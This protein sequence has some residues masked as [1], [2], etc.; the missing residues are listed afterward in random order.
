MDFSKIFEAILKLKSPTDYLLAAFL[1]C[2]LIMFTPSYILLAYPS[3]ELI[4]ACEYTKY[5]PY[6]FVIVSSILFVKIVRWFFTKVSMFISEQY[7]EYKSEKAKIDYLLN[8]DIERMKIIVWFYV[9][10]NNIGRLPP[11]ERITNE[12]VRNDIIKWVPS[13]GYN[14]DGNENYILNEWVIDAINNN[15]RVKKLFM[16]TFPS[17]EIN[18]SET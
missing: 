2:G 4:N 8:L 9:A 14:W 18:E 1:A 7:E 11:R 6:V 16:D 10:E 5:V 13:N 3:E 12:F 15:E 17:K